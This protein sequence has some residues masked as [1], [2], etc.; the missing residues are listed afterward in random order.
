MHKVRNPKLWKSTQNRTLHGLIPNVASA[1]LRSDTQYEHCEDALNELKTVYVLLCKHVYG[2]YAGKWGIA[3]S[4]EL[5][6]RRNQRR[7]ARLVEYTTLGLEGG[8]DEMEIRCRFYTRTPIRNIQVYT[9]FSN[10]KDLDS[11]IVLATRYIKSCYAKGDNGSLTLPE[12]MLPWSCVKWELLDRSTL[13]Q[14]KLDPYSSEALDYIIAKRL[15]INSSYD[16]EGEDIAEDTEL[17]KKE[18]EA[19]Q[20][21]SGPPR[22]RGRPRKKVKT[23]DTAFE[24]EK[25]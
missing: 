5:T 7:A 6:D 11:Q 25:V 18:S 13:Q 1:V 12:F 10:N 2:P 17:P 14:Y 15:R 9:V 23:E 19:A 20:P 24:I 3:S 21:E 22:K 16:E 8:L 4:S